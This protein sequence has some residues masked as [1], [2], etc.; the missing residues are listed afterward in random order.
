MR[1]SVAGEPARALAGACLFL[2]VALGSRASQ[3]QSKAELAQARVDF[4]EGLA[5]QTAGNCAGAIEKFEAVGRVKMTPHVLFNLGLCEERLGRLVAALGH[6]Q[7]ALADAEA[8][9]IAEVSDPS[10]ESIQALE[11]RIPR[12][13]IQRGEGSEGAIIELD[14][15]PI[16]DSSLGKPNRSDPGSHLITARLGDR[17]IFRQ[18]VTLA[19]HEE[20]AITVS[21]ARPADSEPSPAPADA[22][23]STPDVTADRAPSLRTV[24]YVVGGVGVASLVAAGVFVVLR[25][26]AINDLDR[27]CRGTTCPP[28]AEATV[29][30]GRLYTGLAEGG[31]VLGALGLATGAF[32]I[33]S[34]PDPGP[35]SGAI[36]QLRV[37]AGPTSIAVT[38]AF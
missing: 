1:F 34:N 8:Q 30:R 22:P 4:R 18:G 11:A 25:Q 3:A 38:G 10:R 14:G 20:K 5:L 27:M 29:D 33:F 2:A 26:G 6:Y 23:A 19:E 12:L 15:A 7:L 9:K 31:V 28:E 35:K 16:G 36:R 37:G 21:Y 17:T 24:G 13:T 32:L